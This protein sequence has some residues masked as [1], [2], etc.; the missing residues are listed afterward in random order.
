MKILKYGVIALVGL[1]LLAIGG[2]AVLGMQSRGGE[3]LGLIDGALAD[4]P[5]SPNCVSSEAGTPDDKKIEPLA[6]SDWESLPDIIE[7]MGGVVT[8][9]DDSYLAAEFTSGTF[10]FV[11]DL[12]ARLTET[13]V[14][15]RSGSRVGHSDAGVN[16][17]RVADLRERL[18]E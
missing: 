10:G 3:A 17:A 2:L 16:A 9:Q 6:I 7:A 14:H 15:V 18:A 13:N 12:E 11:D 5:A 4:C 8:A 1:V